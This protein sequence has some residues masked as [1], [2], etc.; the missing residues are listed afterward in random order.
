MQAAYE[1]QKA[2]E[3]LKE[4][5]L[6]RIAGFEE[7]VA[8]TARRAEQLAIAEALEKLRQQQREVWSATDR[9]GN[10][11]QPTTSSSRGARSGGK[12]CRPS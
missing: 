11:L 10:K 1:Y 9:N 7:K 5:L 12:A 3:Q 2:L 4:I 8:A 6:A